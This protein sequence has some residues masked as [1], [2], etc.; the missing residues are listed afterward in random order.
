ML[1]RAFSRRAASLSGDGCGGG[2][3]DE[4]LLG[5]KS[6]GSDACCEASTSDAIRVS[7]FDSPAFSPGSKTDPESSF[8]LGEAASSVQSFGFRLNEHVFPS[9]VPGLGSNMG[10]TKLLEAYFFFAQMPAFEPGD[11]VEVRY[12]LCR[13]QQTFATFQGESMCLSV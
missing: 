6:A 1:E 7:R 10:V 13:S 9:S 12:E 3:V 8:L 11:L 2:F 5:W 4:R